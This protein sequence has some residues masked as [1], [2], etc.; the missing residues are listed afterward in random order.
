MLRFNSQ[1]VAV[2]MSARVE[3]SLIQFFDLGVEMT[4]MQLSVLHQDA[5]S[6]KA[7]PNALSHSCVGASAES[8]TALWDLSS[9]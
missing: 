4:V 5:W 1:L 3:Q 9:S 2:V 8:W 7:H 6:M